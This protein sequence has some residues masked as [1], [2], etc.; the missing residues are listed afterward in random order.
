MTKRQAVN[1][2]NNSTQSAPKLTT[3]LAPH[4]VAL[5]GI[6]CSQLDGQA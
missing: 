3:Q 1:R 6:G 2:G 4:L 5:R